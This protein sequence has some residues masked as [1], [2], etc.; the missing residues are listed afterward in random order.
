L[1]VYISL[2]RM[3]TI[4]LLALGCAFIWFFLDL[5]FLGWWLDKYETQNREARNENNAN[6]DDNLARRSRAM[7]YRGLSILPERGDTGAAAMIVGAVGL[8]LIAKGIS[9]CLM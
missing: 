5:L 4:L 3:G 8:A 2:K 1:A 7:F 6:V 9:L